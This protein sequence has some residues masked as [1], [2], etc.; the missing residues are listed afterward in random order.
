MAPVTRVVKYR[1]TV[2]VSKAK[3]DERLVLKLQLYK[4]YRNRG[5]EVNSS[6]GVGTLSTPATL[7]QEAR[8]A[9]TTR[10]CPLECVWSHARSAPAI[11]G[12]TA[13]AVWACG[14]LL[15]P[16]PPRATAKIWRFRSSLHTPEGSQSP[17]TVTGTL[18]G[19][20]IPGS[21]LLE[22]S[23]KWSLH[24]QPESFSQIHTQQPGPGRVVVLFCELDRL[25]EGR[26][27]GA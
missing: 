6:H 10:L 3:A 25:G 20:T 14:Q 9:T 22:L 27:E 15:A 7:G 8:L 18:S 5:P 13:A 11:S 24:R 17:V 26:E 23:G 4:R 16:C 1:F 12:F 2:R 19:G 21:C